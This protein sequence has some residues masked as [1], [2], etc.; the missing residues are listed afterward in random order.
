MAKLFRV[1]GSYEIER[2]PDLVFGDDFV[3]EILHSPQPHSWIDLSDKNNY[4]AL[5]V[6]KWLKEN[7]QPDDEIT[8]LELDSQDKYEQALIQRERD[9]C[10]RIQRLEKE[11]PEF[12]REVKVPSRYMYGE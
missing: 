6:E 8:D 9:F 2:E 4:E 1:F 11:F 5:I 3:S 12:M 10:R 7:P